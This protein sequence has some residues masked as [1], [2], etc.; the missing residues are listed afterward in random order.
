MKLAYVDSSVWI[1]DIEGLPSYRQRI[2]NQLDT[3]ANA[4]WSFCTSELVILEILP[5]L[6]LA[7]NEQLIN[8]Y[9]ELFNQ[10]ILL[11]NFSSLLR[12]A[13]I[14][15]KQEKLKAIDA[16]HVA[17]AVQHGCQCLVSTDTHFRKLQCLMPIWINLQEDSPSIPAR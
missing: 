7:G 6:Y 8:V 5:K 10:L 2:E 4:G 3:L 17:I 14:I 1:A 11:D 15:T 13:L 9:Q 16:I 12:E